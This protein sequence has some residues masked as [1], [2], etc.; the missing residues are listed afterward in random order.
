M[1]RTVLSLVAVRPG[2]FQVDEHYIRTDLDDVVQRDKQVLSLK[3]AQPVFAR[4]G[5]AEHAAFGLGKDDV[6][7]L[8]E[9]APVRHIDD[10][11]AL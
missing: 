10:E 11:L 5:D 9:V 2:I 8:A 1:R 7:R 4:D 6:R 3:K